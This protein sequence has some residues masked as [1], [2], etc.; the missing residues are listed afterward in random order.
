CSDAIGKALEK[1]YT[2]RSAGAGTTARAPS[3]DELPL[4]TASGASE[5]RG[6]EL[7]PQ[8]DRR[9]P[10]APL[11]APRSRG[12]KVQDEPRVQGA[13]NDCGS[14]LSFEEGCVKCH[15]CGFTECG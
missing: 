4:G 7:P 13:C 5:A 12:R 1:Y 8:L 11:A 2:A 14:Q 9:R 10:S 6:V 15:S 3:A